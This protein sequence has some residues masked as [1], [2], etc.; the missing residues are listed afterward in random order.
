MKPTTAKLAYLFPAFPVFHQ[1][2]VLF[3]VLGLQ[4]NGVELKL[5]SLRRP[6]GPQ[7]PEA[8][9]VAQQVTYLPGLLSPAV[10]RANWRRLRR[11]V[12]RYWRTYA[13]VYHA[14]QTGPAGPVRDAQW[15]RGHITLRNRLRGWF[16]TSP[17]LYLLK[18]LLVVPSGIYLAEELERQGVTHLH[19]HWA[20]YPATLAYVVHLVSDLPFSISAHAY[21]IYMVPRMLPAKLGAARFTVTCAQTNARFLRQLGGPAVADKVVVNYHGVDVARFVPGAANGHA[22]EPLRLISCGQLERYKG[23]H[24]LIAACADLVQAGLPLECA[25]VG[26]GVQRRGL[27]EQI[28]RLGL[29]N[30]VRLLGA[31]PQAEV[32]ALLQRS[33]LFVLA[34]ELAGKF[35]RRDV[36]AN[37]VVEAMASGLPVVATQIP[38]MEELVE[39][40]VSGY[41]VPPNS[42]EQIA[43]A[44]A[45][46]ARDPDTRAR[47]GQASRRRILQDFD[48]SKNIRLLTEL[49]LS[50]PRD[51][52]APQLQQCSACG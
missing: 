38:G 4:R 41:L 16:N 29:A 34:S 10:L 12:S 23:M 17:G 8:R 42:P 51:S 36:I 46:L 26:E 2:F 37:V 24:V 50:V 28:E 14:W 15:G 5:Y 3:E 1:T 7:Q 19:A 45:A 25:I 11:G 30:Q 22:R 9:E 48:R 20:S 33:D 52:T 35:G 49:L 21:D 31:R 32:A 44:V 40:G 18:S 43:Q 6:N 13:A 39:D 47:F 27:Q